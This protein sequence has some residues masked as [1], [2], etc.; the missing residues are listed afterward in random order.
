[1]NE[2]RP[3]PQE[4]GPKPK[5]RILELLDNQ[6]LDRQIEG[7][8]EAQNPK[9]YNMLVLKKAI[10]EGVLLE[11]LANETYDDERRPEDFT[12]DVK[13]RE[14]VGRVSTERLVKMLEVK[15]MEFEEELEI[16]KPGTDLYTAYV[17]NI[18]AVDDLISEL[19]R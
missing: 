3:V 19:E 11:N 17:E 13:F 18:D 6:Y 8:N 9:R 14:R 4:S 10:F 12:Q 1:M 2:F 5:N 7:V 16:L 15:K